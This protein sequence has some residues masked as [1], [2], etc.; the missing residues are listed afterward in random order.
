MIR[1]WDPIESDWE[2]I[3]TTLDG[4]VPGDEAGN[5][6]W[7][8]N[9]RAFDESSGRRQHYTVE[10]DGAVIGYGCVEESRDDDP[11]WFRMHICLANDR[12]ADPVADDLHAK[13]W[14]DLQD[15]GAIGAWARE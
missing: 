11:G 6:S 3:L 7:I 8:K 15:L 5:R 13:L 4:I 2:P 1:F 10:E 12:L 14:C 9:R